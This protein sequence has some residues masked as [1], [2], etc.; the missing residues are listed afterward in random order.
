MN[1]RPDELWEVISIRPFGDQPRG[2][3]HVAYKHSKESADEYVAWLGATQYNRGTVQ[4]VTK[5]LREGS[6]L[7]P[8]MDRET[9]LGYLN[10]FLV[11]EGHMSKGLQY[12]EELK[13]V[14][15]TQMFGNTAGPFKGGPCGQMCTE[16]LMEAWSWHNFAVVFCNS[17]IVKCTDNFYM[18]V[19]Y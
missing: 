17:K 5:Y 8:S 7:T 19:E 10:L 12:P 2:I 18:Q 1:K 13:Y 3:Q 14:R 9:A 16:F 4:T 15:W 6:P 11:R